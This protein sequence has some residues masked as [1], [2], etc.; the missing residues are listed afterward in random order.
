[1][2]ARGFSLAM[3][4]IAWS[5][6]ERL[7]AYRLMAQAGM[8]GLEIAPGL[9]FHEAEDPFAPD[10]ASA[11]RKARSALA[12]SGA[13]GSSA[14]WKNRPGAISSPVMPACAISR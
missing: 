12:R 3:S 5:P 1:M 4:N 14:S 9:F 8:T 10:L 6:D 11:S 2:S 13:K 7:D